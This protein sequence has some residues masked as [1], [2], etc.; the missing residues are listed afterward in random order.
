M[1]DKQKRFVFAG[2]NVDSSDLINA[3]RA[4]GCNVTSVSSIE[5]AAKLVDT[6][7]KKGTQDTLFDAIFC[8]TDNITNLTKTSLKEIT[9]PVIAFGGNMRGEQL[10]HMLDQGAT[11]YIP[12]GMDAAIIRRRVNLCVENAELRRLIKEK[13]ASLDALMDDL[14]RVILPIGIALSVEQNTDRLLE[15]ILEEAKKLCCAD[16]G[17]LYLRTNNNELRFAIMRTDS[18]GIQ[19]GGT[20][21]LPTDTLPLLP[22]YDSNGNANNHNIATHV[23]LS[24]ESVNIA[25]IYD[26]KDY[27]WSATRRFD[28]KNKYKSISTLTVPLKDSSSKVIGVLQLFNSINSNT[29]EITSFSAYQQLVFESL[30][31]QTAIVL[32]N[33]SLLKSQQELLVVKR[34]LEIGR[35]IQ[36][37]FIPKSLPQKQGWEVSASLVLA[38][39]VGGDF[40]DAFLPDNTKLIF[41]VADVCDKGVGAALFAS[42]TRSLLRSFSSQCI[43]RGA[44]CSANCV[45]CTPD[46]ITEF[47]K[48]IAR[49]S[50][51]EPMNP[52]C[53]LNMTNDYLIEVHGNMNMF[54]TMF[55]GMIDTETNE[56]TYINAGHEA[57]LII[58]GA[59]KVIGKLDATGPAVGIVPKANYKAKKL[60]LNPGDS[61]V[62]F[63]DGVTDARNNAGN[64][65]TR[66]NLTNVC[67][68]PCACGKD[69]LDHINEA[70]WKHIGDAE[71][72]DDLTLMVIHRTE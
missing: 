23:A 28:Q 46:M 4:E 25:N 13:E 57:P 40:Y 32:A 64:P 56:I 70:V 54:V 63:T 11:D 17:T 50:S 33:Q 38:K 51:V 60:K 45:K 72:F 44:A 53:A 49:E 62:V 18:L 10:A 65:F 14:Q 43:P 19:Y 9:I 36:A 24:G 52:M 3:L 66:N 16:A 8:N 29:G 48:K 31:S 5:E 30:A 69:M 39:E 42:L 59:N 26:S 47:L 71:Q 2:K 34:D 7:A 41:T 27:D 21:G 15:K 35:E 12:D 67:G 6:A 58:S 37:S 61:L 1:S 22:L 20:K 55:F 68:S